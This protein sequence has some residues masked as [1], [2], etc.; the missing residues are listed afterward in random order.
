MSIC[1]RYFIL[2]V[3]LL[4]TTAVQHMTGI[5]GNKYII[6]YKYIIKCCFFLLNHQASY[7]TI[8]MWYLEKVVGTFVNME[9]CV[10]QCE[11]CA[12]LC[13]AFHTK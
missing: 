8:L 2:E 9:V 11:T 5:E 7:F 1:K 4:I 6:T 13:D 12:T 10:T 3:L